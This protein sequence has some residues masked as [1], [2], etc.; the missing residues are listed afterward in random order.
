M[1]V[2]WVEHK[3]FL[4]EVNELLVG[5]SSLLDVGCGI[6][7]T[8]RGLNCSIKVGVDIHRPYLE[9][10]LPSQGVIPVQLDAVQ[11]SK[12][13]LPKSFDSV[14]FIDVIEH[15]EKEAALSVLNQ[16]ETIALQKV[17]VFTPR[18]FFRQDDVDLLNLGG[19]AYQRHRSGW[20]IDDFSRLGYKV[21]VFRQFHDADNSSF[22]RTYGEGASPIDA[23]LA[24]KDMLL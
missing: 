10:C 19:E 9:K 8:L 14:T 1:S 12:V 3:D 6:G 7:T 4:V 20:E 23:L 16:A 15:F 18:G 17:I 5:S 24:W 2:L 13:I 11:L 21:M 22:R